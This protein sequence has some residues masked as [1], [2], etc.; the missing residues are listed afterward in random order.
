[1]LSGR[2]IR[3]C[4]G[5]GRRGRHFLAGTSGSGGGCAAGARTFWPGHQ[6]VAGAAPQRP[7][8]SGRDIRKWRGLRC[9]GPHFLARTSGSAGGCAAGA[10]TFWPGHQEVAGAAPQ[11]APL[12]GRDIR[13][14]RGLRRRGRH[15]L[16]G[17]SGSGGGC[18]AEAAPFW[19]GHQEVVGAA[20]QGPA[21]S[22]RD[23]RKWWGLRHRGGCFLGAA[24]REVERERESRSSASRGRAG[25]RGGGRARGRG[26]GRAIGRRVVGV[27]GS[28]EARQI[29]DESAEG[30]PQ[31]GG[32]PPSRRGSDA[33]HES[34]GPRTQGPSA[35]RSTP[36][37]SEVARSAPGG[38]E[39]GRLRP[40]PG[41]WGAKRPTPGHPSRELAPVEGT[42]SPWVHNAVGGPVAV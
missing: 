30:D 22:G 8:L 27:P 24:D 35:L 25:A 26:R 7:P 32:L 37:A 20:A 18:A 17:T 29:R 31:G 1:M 39:G 15:F 11:R 21:P 6:E 10:R 36:T 2:D 41:V 14:W 19:P 16:A 12:S 23:I 33:R 3:K 9:R 13:K 42:Q 38:P 28:R 34:P 4:W 40:V 5:L